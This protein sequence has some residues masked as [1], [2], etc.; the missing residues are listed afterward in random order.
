M[1]LQPVITLVI[2]SVCCFTMCS[3][4]VSADTDAA[5]SNYL[6]AIKEIATQDNIPLPALE[7]G[8]LDRDLLQLGHVVC[9]AYRQQKTQTQVTDFVL[10]ASSKCAPAPVLLTVIAAAEIYLCPTA[11]L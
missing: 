10:S 1:R 4:K 6:N 2:V 11:A 5:A 3:A 8:S 7:N 9:A